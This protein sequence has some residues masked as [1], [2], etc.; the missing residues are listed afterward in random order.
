MKSPFKFLDA[1]TLADKDVFFGREEE[2]K[3]LYELVYKTRLV[4][5]YGLSGTGKT[6][7]IQCGLAARFDGTDWYPFTIRRQDNIN[8]SL[9]QNDS[10]R[11][12]RSGGWRIGGQIAVYFSVLYQPDLSD[13]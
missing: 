10:K 2:V 5:L 4:L 12:A 9:A 6:S 8:V 3:N 7:V 11:A 1:F 13:F